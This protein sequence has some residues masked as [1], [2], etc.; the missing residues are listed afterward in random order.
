MGR[1]WRSS[2]WRQAARDGSLSSGAGGD[3][4]RGGDSSG[5]GD[6][7]NVGHDDT[8]PP[9]PQSLGA[10]WEDVVHDK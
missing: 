8:L 3:T 6:L 9:E 1:M 5:H 2:K 10:V 7:W 4:A